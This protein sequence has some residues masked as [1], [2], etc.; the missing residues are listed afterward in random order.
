MES[1][2]NSIEVNR[3]MLKIIA[4]PST[5]PIYE[6]IIKLEG[7]MDWHS[8]ELFFLKAYKQCNCFKLWKRLFSKEH[9]VYSY[10]KVYKCKKCIGYFSR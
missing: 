1:L 4:N 2:K 8:G 6:T 10:A 9:Q 7:S 3:K 5:S